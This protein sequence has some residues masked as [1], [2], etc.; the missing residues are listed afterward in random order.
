MF[1]HK[2]KSL[3]K[4]NS[5]GSMLNRK[6]IMNKLKSYKTLDEI[7]KNPGLP[8]ALAHIDKIRLDLLTQNNFK[9]NPTKVTN[10]K[11]QN[12]INN[13]N[14]F[15]K[16]Y[17]NY[18]KNIKHSLDEIN[19]MTK[20]N[21]Q[22][23]EKYNNIIVKSN[24]NNKT[25]NAFSDIRAQYEKQDYKLPKL[26]NEN[27]LFKSNLLLSDNDNELKKYIKYGLVTQKSFKK[28]LKFLERMNH[29]IN[30]DLVDD[31]QVYD[32]SIFKNLNSDTTNKYNGY[33]FSSSQ[34]FALNK[35]PK[36][37]LKEIRKYRKDI[38]KIKR[39]IKSMKDIDYFFSS[40][41]KKYLDSLRHFNSRNTSSNFSTSLGNNN[42]SLFD[43]KS[44]KNKL[45]LNLRNISK[46][47]SDENS[48]NKRRK[49]LKKKVTFRMDLNKLNS[50][51]EKKDKENDKENKS[52]SKSNSK[53]EKKK[54]NKKY[55]NKNINKNNYKK[56]LETLY[57]KISNSENTTIYDKKI[58][59]YL[60]FRK[61]K[62]DHK[63]D[64]N[65]IC[66]NVE[67]LRDKICKDESIKKV[68]GLR[69]SVGNYF[70]E[71]KIFD[72]KEL[73]IEKKVNDIEDEMIKAFS[74]FK[75]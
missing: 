28:T 36:Q 11:K 72:N 31:N 63:I 2:A 68:I 10:I 75:N 44:P 35:M 69:R 65:I 57:N 5:D 1:V 56:T 7:N 19:D 34:F 64:E 14:T 40:D 43:K 24:N 59:S 39:T 46:L 9:I 54:K 73:E 18:N 51:K 71:N 4:S 53:S 49:I 45:I 41:N 20:Y 27:N 6:T 37:Q 12:L 26:E 33:R 66:N 17:Y 58:R 22:F 25:S 70:K 62:L 3:I 32:I 16:I 61:Y 21:T 23:I 48:N 30:N 74:E 8:L 60:K 55:I 52:Q 13:I 42:S 15:R 47:S 29:K 67:I 50:D 38:K